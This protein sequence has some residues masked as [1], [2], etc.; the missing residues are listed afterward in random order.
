M[1]YTVENPPYK[2]L[3]GDEVE[4]EFNHKIYSYSVE[5]YYLRNS[6]TGD[7][8]EIFDILG[9]N[10]LGLCSRA[11][12]QEP[13]WEERRN[14]PEMNS[15]IRIERQKALTRVVWLLFGE[16]LHRE[17]KPKIDPDDYILPPESL[18]RMNEVLNLGDWDPVRDE[19][20]GVAC[21]ILGGDFSKLLR[22]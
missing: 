4:F 17:P 2:V 3:V 16:I 7:N 19:I 11:Y 20:K 6:G 15:D 13:L 1:R 12:G 22:I 9:L 21:Q 10:P 5:E 18:G 8:S 14:W